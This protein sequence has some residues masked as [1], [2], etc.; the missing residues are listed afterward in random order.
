MYINLKHRG[1]WYAQNIAVLKKCTSH[2]RHHLLICCRWGIGQHF[3]P[4]SFNRIRWPR[5]WVE[6]S[7]DST[8]IVRA[9]LNVQS[10]LYI[11][12]QSYEA[13]IGSYEIACPAVNHYD[14]GGQ[15]GALNTGVPCVPGCASTRKLEPDKLR[16]NDIS[17][18][19]SAVCVQMVVW[20][21]Q[22]V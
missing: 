12:Q 13:P 9:C 18:W 2:L 4:V 16:V 15:T 8:K 17:V 19:A 1:P 7:Y 14:Q 3:C 6:R 5:S 20:V 10:S 11:T 21:Y 22:C